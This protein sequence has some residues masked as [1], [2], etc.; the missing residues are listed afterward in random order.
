MKSSLPSLKR[1]QGLMYNIAILVLFYQIPLFFFLLLSVIL[2]LS[3]G[4][5]EN[6]GT[7]FVF[8][9]IMDCIVSL[10]VC[11][12]MYL[13]QRHNLLAY[14]KFIEIIYKLKIHIL[15]CC[16]FNRMVVAQYSKRNVHPIHGHP[17]LNQI[18]RGYVNRVNKEYNMNVPKELE[19][20][21]YQYVFYLDD[22]M[23]LI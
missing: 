16:C 22:Q 9:T 18:I 12:S 6:F 17:R 7:V 23:K 14:E 15:C 1:I 3:R 13:M 8:I 20:M 2:I 10:S 19:P 4:F 11:I 21:I 5:I